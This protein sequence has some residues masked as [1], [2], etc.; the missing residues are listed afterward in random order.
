[1]AE[2]VKTCCNE[3]ENI[4]YL[5]PESSSSS[6]LSIHSSRDVYSTSAGRRPSSLRR[7]P[8]ASATGTGSYSP[9]D[10]RRHRIPG[11]EPGSPPYYPAHFTIG[12]VIDLGDGALKRVEELE[13]DDFVRSAETSV[14]LRLDTSTVIH[15]E[16][17]HVRNTAVLGF[18]VGQP[19]N[20]VL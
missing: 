10:R 8:A 16:H 14:E 15:M 20:E 7:T 17:D 11:V 3:T 18:A 4:N 5:Y 2:N 19:R 9:T 6:L 13:T 1:M 12:S